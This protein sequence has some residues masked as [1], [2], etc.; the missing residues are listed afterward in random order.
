MGTVVRQRTIAQL[1][2]SRKSLSVAMRECC[3]NKLMGIYLSYVRSL[4]LKHP[5]HPCKVS[6]L[7]RELTNRMRR[8][9]QKAYAGKRI[10]DT[11][12][13]KQ[14]LAR[15]AKDKKQTYNGYANFLRSVKLPG[16]QVSPSHWANVPPAC[17]QS[18][19]FGGRS[20]LL[21]ETKQLGNCAESFS[22]TAK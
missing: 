10:K 19:T 7:Y 21:Y 14:T 5:F 1:K 3:D 9:G 17:Q 13:D 12:G 4:G 16:G 8:I 2:T 11:V 6:T 22:D 15:L 18:W 20:A